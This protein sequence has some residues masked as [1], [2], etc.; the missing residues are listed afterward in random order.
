MTFTSQHSYA[1][2]DLNIVLVL[3]I[4][5]KGLDVVITSSFL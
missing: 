3:V 1:S 2:G 4:I 5:S